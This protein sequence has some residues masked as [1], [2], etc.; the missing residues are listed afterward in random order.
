MCW[1]I[2]SVYEGY[3]SKT[4]PQAN[5]TIQQSRIDS[6]TSSKGSTYYPS[7]IY[8]YTV[9]GQS[10]HNSRIGTRGAWNFETSRQIVDA[11]PAGSQRPIYYSPSNPGQSMLVP[12]LQPASFF[13]IILGTLIFSFGALLGSVGYLASKYGTSYSGRSYSF[14]NNSPVGPIVF[15]GIV[16]ILLQFG[17]MFWL[18]R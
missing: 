7:I 16:A 11:N 8:I 9:G 18:L 1:G 15:V 6:S 2:S 5:G 17:L 4:W 13:G 3:V 12:G 14:D 10:Y